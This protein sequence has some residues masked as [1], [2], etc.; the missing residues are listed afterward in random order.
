MIRMPTCGVAAA[1]LALP[2]VG[3]IPT[4]AVAADMAVIHQ[5]AVADIDPATAWSRVG[6]FCDI[7]EWLP[8]IKD[9]ELLSGDGTNPGTVRRLNF[10]DEQILVEPMVAGGDMSYSYGM[11]E[12]FLAGTLY[13]GT[14][15]VSAGPRDGT[16]TITWS[17]VINRAAFPSADEADSMVATL[18]GV[19]Q[20][21]IDGLRNLAEGL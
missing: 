18:N 1:L 5:E 16:S 12:G 15:R 3:G 9:C 4:M 10:N 13:T 14:V 19:Y 6:G 20:T 11:T 17:A 8:P 2:L 21:G 7:V